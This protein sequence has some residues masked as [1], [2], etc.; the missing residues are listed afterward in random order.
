MPETADAYERADDYTRIS[1]VL[2][3]GLDAWVY[4]DGHHR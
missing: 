3:S 4:V 2:A 1:V